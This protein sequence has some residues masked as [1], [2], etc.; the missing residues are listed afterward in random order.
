VDDEKKN[1][2]IGGGV[3]EKWQ[4]LLSEEHAISSFHRMLHTN[5]M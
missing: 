1:A 3:T 5:G 2:D 4:K